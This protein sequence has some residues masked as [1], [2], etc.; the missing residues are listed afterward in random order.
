[1]EEI[2]VGFLVGWFVL[3]LARFSIFLS[4]FFFPSLYL[5]MVV[6][7]SSSIY[8]QIFLSSFFSYSVYK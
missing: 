5:S 8:I 7:V 6:K 3:W 2:R 1:V 4:F